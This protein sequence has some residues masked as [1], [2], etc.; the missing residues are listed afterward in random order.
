MCLTKIPTKGIF[1]QQK[2]LRKLCLRGYDKKAKT[3]KDFS[4]SQLYNVAI[5]LYNDVLSGSVA[6]IAA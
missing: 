1:T 6:L 2:R 5:F 4:I 3:F